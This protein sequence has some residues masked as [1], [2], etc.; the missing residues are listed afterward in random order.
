MFRTWNQ[1]CEIGIELCD[2]DLFVSPYD[3]YPSVIVEEHGQVMET[4][5]HGCTRPRAL[6]A[7]RGEKLGTFAVDIA[8]DIKRTIVVSKA[9]RPNALAVYVLMVLQSKGGTHI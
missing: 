7:T 5:L 8:E 1:I 3:V 4:A 6:G 9:G 2:V